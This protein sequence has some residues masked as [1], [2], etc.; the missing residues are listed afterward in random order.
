MKGV[1]LGQL[2]QS[3]LDCHVANHVLVVP[4]FF[5]GG[6]VLPE[7]G[8]QRQLVNDLPHLF[9]HIV[10]ELFDDQILGLSFEE[11]VVQV[12]VLGDT[13]DGGPETVPDVL[14]LFL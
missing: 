11:L 9:L 10:L 14:D 6:L 12:V 2:K 1:D 5:L 8:F 7:T 4:L 13:F 3:Q